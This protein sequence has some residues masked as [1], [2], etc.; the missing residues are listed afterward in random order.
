MCSHTII[1]PNIS[2]SGLIVRTRCGSKWRADFTRFGDDCTGV[3]DAESGQHSSVFGSGWSRSFGIVVRFWGEKE[4]GKS[5][6]KE[7][8]RKVVVSEKRNLVIWWQGGAILDLASSRVNVALTRQCEI[9]DGGPHPLHC[10]VNKPLSSEHLN[11]FG[12][13]FRHLL[14]L[15]VNP[16]PDHNTK[17]PR[18]AWNKTPTSVLTDVASWTRTKDAPAQVHQ[19]PHPLQHTTHCCKQYSYNGDILLR[20][21]LELWPSCSDIRRSLSLKLWSTNNVV[22]I[23]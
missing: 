4:N 20:D 13:N 6:Q 23:L 14:F 18:A 5:G 22:F 16:K 9:K 11:I 15:V 7:S 10:C 3:H 1:G 2:E 17:R 19:H 8:I 21:E 12:L